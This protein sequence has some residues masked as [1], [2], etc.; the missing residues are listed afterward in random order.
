MTSNRRKQKSNNWKNRQ[1]KDQYVRNACQQGF[2][3]R[4]VYKLSQIDEKYHLLKSGWV[5][6]DLGSAP[7]SWTQYAVSKVGEK[8]LVLS[9][10]RLNMPAV[11][12]THFILGDFTDP[13]VLDSV[14]AQ[15]NGRMVDLVLSD[16]A[17]NISGIRI[18]DQANMERIAESVIAFSRRSLKRGGCMLIKLF[19]GE[20][21]DQV[22]VQLKKMFKMVDHLKP[23]ASR[24]KSSE[25]YLFCR[26]HKVH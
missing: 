10:D 11:E 26:G 9:V 16:M 13:D 15:L 19:E 22:R 24:S 17:P 5:V 1:Q 4:S 21:A 25:F 3:A 2:R 6:V 18:S 7:G 20:S 8:G 14:N 23:P 12:N